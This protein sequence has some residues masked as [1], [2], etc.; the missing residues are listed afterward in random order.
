MN[1]LESDIGN[2]FSPIRNALGLLKKQDDTGRHT[3][4]PDERRAISS[5]LSAPIQTFIKEDITGFL[6]TIKNVIEGGESI[7]KD[8]KREKALKWIDH[9]LNIDLSGIRNKRE[10]RQSRIEETK[11]TISDMTISKEREDIEKS[12]VY[13][14]GQF[15]RSQEEKTRLERHI[16]SLEEELAEKKQ[17]LSE[18]LEEIAGKEIEV[19]FD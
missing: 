3:L 18:A 10:Q 6:C 15:T 16:T 7:L 2:L 17:L 9:L 13:A 8:R 12:I 4:T 1:K 14:E 11:S 19:K 5:I